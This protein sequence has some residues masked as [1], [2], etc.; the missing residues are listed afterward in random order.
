MG[1]N[2]GDDSVNGD[3]GDDINDR[4]SQNMWR[5]RCLLN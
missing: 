1:V 3:D 2:D 4:N 5:R